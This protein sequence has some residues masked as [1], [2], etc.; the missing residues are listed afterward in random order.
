MCLVLITLITAITLG[1]DTAIAK[2]LLITHFGLFLL[3]QPVF[4]QEE[5]FSLKSLV[6]L[7]LFT[8]VFITWINLWSTTFWVLLLSSLINGRIFARGLNRATYGLAGIIL[9]LELTLVLTPNLFDL[10]GIQQTLQTS[11]NIVL[12]IMALPL[13]FIPSSNEDSTHV[14]FIRGFMVV[15]LTLF[16]CMGSVLAS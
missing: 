12:L 3:W 4:R 16:L 14:D 2:S 10:P 6:I 5:S 8:S 1:V 15:F 13:L 7:L 9:F 11:I